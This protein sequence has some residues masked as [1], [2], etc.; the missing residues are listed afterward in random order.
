[1]MD[2]C[3]VICIK[4]YISAAQC[5]FYI[6]LDASRCTFATSIAKMPRI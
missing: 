6:P 5:V 1:M 4:R 2:Y 3:L